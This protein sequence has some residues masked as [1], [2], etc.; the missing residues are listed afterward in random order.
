MTLRLVGT[1]AILVSTILTATLAI[2]QAQTIT[3][4]HTYVMGGRDSKDEARA[5]C[6]MTAKRKVLEQAGVLIESSSEVRNFDLTKDQISSYSEAILSVEVVKEAFEFHNGTNSL[7]LTVKANVDMAEVRKRLAEI[8]AD[9]GLQAK[10]DAQQQQIRKMEQQLQALNEKLSGASAGSESMPFLVEIPKR[11]PAWVVLDS[12]RHGVLP[13]FGVKN[14]LR[15]CP[16]IDDRPVVHGTGYAI[17][18]AA[19]GS[20]WVSTRSACWSIGRCR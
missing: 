12:C 14:R 10:V 15:I 16:R 17:R 19:T 20:G 4:T 9:K 7:T 6:Y 5:L 18:V 1:F 11:L 13:T 2:A 8:V 3:A